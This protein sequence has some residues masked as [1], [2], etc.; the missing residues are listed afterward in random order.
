MIY[1]VTDAMREI[2][3]DVSAK[4]L[5]ELQAF[6][7]DIKGVFYQCGHA[8]EI[9]ETLVEYDRLPAKRYEKFPLVMLIEDVGVEYGGSL[10]IATFRM[11]I[12]HHTQPDY[13]SA[14]R[15]DLVFKPVLRPIYE[16]LIKSMQE[17]VFFNI[18]DYQA[19]KHK[20]WDRKFWG[21][22]GEN[23][24][25]ENKFASAYIDAI[26]MQNIRI[27]VKQKSLC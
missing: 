18:P 22:L 20:A 4:M 5:P 23:G 26:D 1:V 7:P 14:Q 12:A 21:K 13:K 11:V 25:E 8:I 17:A 3:A 10:P 15:E 27:E 24:N 19:I 16:S 6:D 2:V 9:D